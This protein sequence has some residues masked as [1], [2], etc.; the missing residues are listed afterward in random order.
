MDESRGTRRTPHG[1]IQAVFSTFL[2]AVVL[3]LG[4]GGIFATWPT[5][6]TALR[7][8]RPPALPAFP[9]LP[10]MSSGGVMTCGMFAFLALM[11]FGILALILCCCCKCGG[12][13]LK[14]GGFLKPLIALL[15]TTATGMRAA[16]TAAKAMK[17]ALDAGTTAIGDV[18][19][20]LNDIK[21]AI[22][23][24]PDVGS[25][26]DFLTGGIIVDPHHIGP[27][28]LKGDFAG[29]NVVPDGIS[30]VQLRVS[31]VKTQVGKAGDAAGDLE[32]AM[33]TAADALDSIANLLE[34]LTL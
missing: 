3:L 18:H 16:A 11:L 23:N 2:I 4:I 34:S 32:K 6:S 17:A 24:P 22:Q 5:F 13:S 27:Q 30:E 21:V 20:K 19:N 15:R 10:A 25:L 28:V 29:A 12:G 31:D 8:G 7:E 26:A 33:T 9:T 14:I 1:G